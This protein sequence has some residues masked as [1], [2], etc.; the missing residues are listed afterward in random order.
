MKIIGLDVSTKST[1]WFITKR[2]CGRIIPAERLSFPEKLVFFRSE[3]SKLLRKH[4][5]DVAVIED[6]YYRP[7]KGSI[8]TLKALSKFAGVAIEVCT[9]HDAEAVIITA[10]SARKYCCG[11]HDGPFKKPEVFKFFVEKYN[12]DWD[13]TTHNDITDA[14]ALAWAYRELERIEKKK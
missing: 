8:H 12:L 4:K 13:Y 9:A 5:P 11:E 14:M 10:T 2:S 3:L 7:R 6:V 1:G